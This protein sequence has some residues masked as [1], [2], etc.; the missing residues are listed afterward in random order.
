MVPSIDNNMSRE[1]I[2]LTRSSNLTLLSINSS[3]LETVYY[4]SYVYS[5]GKTTRAI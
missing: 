5:N 3:K 1:Q 4:K 2:K